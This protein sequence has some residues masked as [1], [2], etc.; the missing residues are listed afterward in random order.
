MDDEF[1]PVIVVFASRYNSVALI[2]MWIA[3]NVVM[4]VSDLI[5]TVWDDSIVASL[6]HFLNV[7]ILLVVSPEFIAP[8]DS[9]CRTCGP[10]HKRAGAA[11]MILEI[12]F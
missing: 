4:M 9:V 5:F 6:S 8:A 10:V 3:F 12:G 1:V 11:V 2:N 7:R